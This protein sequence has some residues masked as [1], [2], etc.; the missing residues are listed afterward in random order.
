[1]SLA[2]I[3]KND[4]KWRSKVCL[5][6]WILKTPRA[7]NKFERFNGCKTFVRKTIILFNIVENNV[8][9]YYYYSLSDEQMFKLEY[10]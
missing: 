1:M 10:I 5:R 7:D 3:V 9:H 6:D 4:D 2:G 8:K